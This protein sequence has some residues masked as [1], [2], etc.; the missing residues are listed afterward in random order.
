MPN[1]VKKVFVIVSK[2]MKTEFL[3]FSDLG[4]I[5]PGFVQASN[6]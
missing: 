6:V 2:E 1:H 3:S 5:T 4:S